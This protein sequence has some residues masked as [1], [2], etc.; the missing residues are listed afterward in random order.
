MS[1]SRSRSAVLDIA[2]KISR[3]AQQLDLLGSFLGRELCPSIKTN[4]HTKNCSRILSTRPIAQTARIYFRDAS[5]SLNGI[6]SAHDNAI[7][8]LR[9]DRSDIQ[10]ALDHADKKV[11]KWY[12]LLY[13]KDD[14]EVGEDKRRLFAERTTWW[15]TLDG[16]I[17]ELL[18]GREIVSRTMNRYSDSSAGLDVLVQTLDEMAGREGLTRLHCGISE[19][20]GIERQFKEVVAMA[21]SDDE[22]QS[23]EKYYDAL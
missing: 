18:T 6:L 23:F 9:A 13:Q 12:A 22:G 14:K 17:E 8:T 21:A 10:Q 4:V 11:R 7:D 20:E 3:G 15:D 2:P 19:A 5:D 16:A 1:L